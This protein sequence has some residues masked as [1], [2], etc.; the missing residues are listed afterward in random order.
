M[1]AYAVAVWG[2]NHAQLSGE[3]Y[4]AK[5]KYY[6]ELLVNEFLILQSLT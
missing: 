6:Q 1:Y 4:V 3:L 2:L 5:I